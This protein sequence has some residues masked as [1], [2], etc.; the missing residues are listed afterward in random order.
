MIHYLSSVALLLAAAA[1]ATQVTNNTFAS[2]VNCACTELS[3]KLPDS[4]LVPTSANFTTETKHFWD[5]R[6]AVSPACMFFPTSADEVSEGVATLTSCNAEFAI[7]GGG[8]MN[9]PGANNIAGG[10]LMAL[11]RLDEIVVNEED[12]TVSIGPGNT[13]ADVY[14]ALDPYGLYTNGGRL[15]T[16][17]V[18][19]LS[20]IGGFHYFINKFGYT[21]DSM[22]SYDVVLGNGTQVVASAT[23]NPDLFWALKGGA[24]NFGI[25]TKF[26]MQ[27]YKIPQISTTIQAF[28]EASIEKFIEAAGEMA[29]NSDAE[30]GAGS[31]LSISYNA[32]TDSL[33]ASLLG[34]QEG[35]ESPPSRF[36]AFDAVP[37]I[38][39]SDNITTPAVWHSVLET[40]NQLWR[41]Q[42]AHHTVKAT[43]TARLYEILKAWKVA[44]GE[45]S[46]VQGL[47]A[48]FVL[49]T[50]PKSAA[51]VAKTNAVGNVWGLEDEESLIIWQL[52]TGWDNESDDLR[53]T[54][55]SKNFIEY[56]HSINQNLG[57][58]SEF[59]YMG[60]AGEFQNP[61]LGFPAANVEKLR[62]VRASYDPN[63]VFVK[64]NWGGFKLSV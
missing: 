12:C 44:V 54:A 34:V 25:V 7:R 35:N 19:G 57:V 27:A 33:S 22:R 53:M 15:K 46:D 6:S 11:N 62:E 29:I 16:I 18:P 3:Q 48:T 51:T 60:D 5:I 41:I 56:H 10:V 31:V 13:W 58:A 30:V 2:R 40:P 43:A 52:S 4:V 38:S 28:D 32:T 59:V 9:F 1:K 8:H 36:A 23:E 64:L 24:N 61:Y 39:R 55:W 49:N 37:S 14:G 20:L 63:Q 45:V 42:F 21:M 47:H 26:V 50:M 17:G